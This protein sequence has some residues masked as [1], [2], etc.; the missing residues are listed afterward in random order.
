MR[1]GFSRPWI[2]SFFVI[3]SC[4]LLAVSGPVGADEKRQPVE[5]SSD[6]KFLDY[7]DGSIL[8]I[9]TK[10]MWIKEDY[11]QM[12]GKWVNWY[13]ANEYAQR[14]NNKNFAGYSDWRLPTPEEAQTLYDRRKR[15]VDKDGDKIYIDTIFPKGPGWSTWT[16]EDKHN[17]AVVVSYKDEGGRSYQD[18]IS[19]ED[20]FL[21]L[22]RGPV[23]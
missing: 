4:A 18:K 8:N 13:T 9:E 22:V 20:A 7:G 6:Q 10:L 19:G 1:Y 14:M 12:N 3:A 5:V 2:L 21:R 11:W 16:S 23:S 15:N 17:K